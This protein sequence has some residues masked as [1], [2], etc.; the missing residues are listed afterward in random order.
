MKKKS[1]FLTGLLSAVMALSLFALPA[2]A[3]NVVGGNGTENA[4]AVT[5]VWGNEQSGSITIHKYE[6]NRPDGKEGTPATGAVLGNNDIPE[7]A[8]VLQGAKFRIFKVQ[9][10]AALAEYYSGKDFTGNANYEKFTNV[11]RYYEKKSDGTFTVK[12]GDGVA[13][14]GSDEKVTNAQGEATFTIENKDFGLYLV[15]ETYAPDKVKEKQVP[16][17]V[18]VPMQD[19]SDRTAWLYNVHVYPKNATQYG[20]VKI[21]KVGI[22]GS[23]EEVTLG[24]VT[25]ELYKYKKEGD[26][27]VPVTTRDDDATKALNLT[28]NNSGMISI[29]GLSKGEYKLV[30]KKF[31][32]AEGNKG[33]IISEE[34]ITFTIGEDGGMTTSKD[35]DADGNIVVKNYRPDLDKK[36]YNDAVISDKND[37]YVDG[38]DYSV[39]DMVPYQITVKIPQN[40]TK[41]KVF[42]VTD[43]PVNL[44][45]QKNT[46]AI[47][48][49]TDNKIVDAVDATSGKTIYTVN[50]ITED[51]NGFVIKF[52]P[53]N[54]ENYAGHTLVISYKA[55]LL[56]AAKK[57]TEGNKNNATLTYTNTIDETGEG[58]KGSENTI[59]NE[60]VVY[61]FAIRI[62]K[63]GENNTPLAGAKF[64]LYKKLEAGETA[65]GGATTVTGGAAAKL[66]LDSKYNWV[67]VE[68]DLESQE[69]TGLVTTTKGLA[70]GTYYLVETQAPA[71]YNL[72]AKP[73]EV[74]VNVVYKYTWKA[75]DKYDADG[76][77]V[78]H[79]VKETKEA[80]NKEQDGEDNNA[81]VVGEENG[82][83]VDGETI[84][85]K[86]VKVINRKGI[87]LPVTGGF[88]TLLFSGIGALLVVGGVGVLMSIK[89]KKGNT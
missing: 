9:N 59:K 30:E 33:Y 62:F 78:K 89:K 10:R 84:G 6:Y 51:T 64:N 29:G 47:T 3:D 4:S 72:L 16:F 80:F 73:V 25:F 1:R 11:N 57:T 74:T 35:K 76:N 86:E 12:N 71:G 7:G 2:A 81:E 46:I 66:G 20:D 15:V 5:D 14:T 13:V 75:T 36:V 48:D 34:P 19:P 53:A 27:W 82:K 63:V 28:T 61:T 77:L 68:E 55:K 65:P 85:L 52:D 39:G 22:T 17:L 40:I 41:L 69:D 54:M 45:D 83:A 60:T 24:G 32:G 37:G 58:K 56:D 70:N 88:G 44:E 49:V 26:E 87:K 38:S 21:K 43:S 31:E 23:D 8:K 42:T 18:S 79:E 67:L 50:S